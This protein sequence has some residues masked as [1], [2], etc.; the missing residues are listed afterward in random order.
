MKLALIGVG[1]IGGSFAKAL[2]V[3]GAVRHI[4][5]FD[6][7]P[8]ELR[9]AVE[10]GVIDEAAASASEA[11]DGADVVMIATPVGSTRQVLRS[12][13]SHLSNVAVVT[14]VGSTKSSVIEGAR[15]ELGVA[16]ERFV[17]GHPIAGSERSGVQSSRADLFNQSL[18]ISTP[19]EQTHDKALQTVEQL[20]RGIGCRIERMSA[21]EHDRVFAAVSHLP[22][23][24]AFALM[25]YI[26][27]QPDAE[28]K[29]AMAGTGFRNLTRLAGSSP[30][31]WGDI[32]SANRRALTAELAGYRQWLDRWQHAIETRDT[33]FIQ[34][35]F[36]SASTERRAMDQPE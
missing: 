24:I 3:T 33:A 30:Q 23:V 15:A 28:R 1:L 25:N 7:D 8:P 11:T 34:G 29:L 10:L 2:R 26:S 14:D 31:M 27:A 5:G 22:H 32:C 36:E 18:F 12:I 35:F 4:V 17:P 9:A 16:F 21:D 19:T 6:V 13:L 20:W